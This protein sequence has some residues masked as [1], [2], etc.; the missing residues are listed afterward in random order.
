MKINLWIIINILGLV[1]A[2]LGAFY[3]FSPFVWTVIYAIL[4]IGCFVL[5]TLR[6]KRDRRIEFLK[7]KG[8]CAIVV[9]PICIL[10]EF[11]VLSVGIHCFKDIFILHFAYHIWDLFVDPIITVYVFILM[12]AIDTVDA[13]FSYYFEKE[14]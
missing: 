3:E 9:F 10:F 14:V 7:S 13:E 11:A 2:F 5:I 12:D 6:T 4:T 8:L 1:L